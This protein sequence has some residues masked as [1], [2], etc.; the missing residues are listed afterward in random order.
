MNNLVKIL[1]T[2][3]LIVA[4]ALVLKGVFGIGELGIKKITKKI[5]KTPKTKLPDLEC[6]LRVRGET[7]KQ[8]FDLQSIRDNTP[9]DIPKD[10]MDQRKYFSKDPMFLQLVSESDQD[11]QYIVNVINNKNGKSKGALFKINRTT[12][13][14]EFV[15]PG[16]RPIGLS[17]KENIDLMG[18]AERFYG[19]CVRKQIKM[20]NNFEWDQ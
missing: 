12:G 13:D 4:I 5:T 17:L 7:N 6:T 2:L 1:A 3:G 9:K 11:N 19:S 10:L 8:S 18:K 14:L 15:W 20:K 16:E